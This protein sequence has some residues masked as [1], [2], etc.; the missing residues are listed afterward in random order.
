MSMQSVRQQMAA[1]RTQLHRQASVPAYYVVSGSA[2]TPVNVRLHRRN[3]PVG[4]GLQGH[5]SAFD[6]LPRIVFL[7]VDLSPAGDSYVIFV[8][9]NEVYFIKNVLPSDG[10]VIIVETVLLA[11]SERDQIEFA[12][13]AADLATDLAADA[14]GEYRYLIDTTVPGLIKS[15][16][17]NWLRVLDDTIVA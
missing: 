16:G 6:I 15:D 7:A 13:T 10:V 5:A 14:S 17:V 12:V 3:A 11:V 1:G 8:E 2:A 4:D 9:T